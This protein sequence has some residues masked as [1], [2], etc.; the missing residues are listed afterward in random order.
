MTTEQR[1]QYQRLLFELQGKHQELNA[2][3]DMLSA[4]SSV[5]QLSVRRMKQH[6]LR[7]KDS[8]SRLRSRLIPDLD[9]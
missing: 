3:I 4:C 5:D 1:L 8:I 2:L 9:A 6:R 7:L